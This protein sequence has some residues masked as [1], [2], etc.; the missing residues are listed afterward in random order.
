[1]PQGKLRMINLLSSMLIIKKL[2][3]EELFI[4]LSHFYDYDT[5]VRHIELTCRSY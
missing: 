2:F 3:L 1:M 4:D 5:V